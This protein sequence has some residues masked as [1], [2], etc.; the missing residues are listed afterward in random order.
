MEFR[1]DLTQVTFAL[2][3]ALDLVGE[4][5]IQHG[6][7]V[8]YIAAECVGALDWPRRAMG[9][10]FLASVLH[11]CGVSST[12]VHHNLLERFEVEDP[13]AHCERGHALLSEFEPFAAVAD[14]VRRHHTPWEEISPVERSDRAVLSANAIFLADRVDVFLRGRSTEE[15]LLTRNEIVGVVETHAGTHFA[16]LL[17]QAFLEAA[18]R[19]AFWLTLEPRHLE[20]YLSGA[21]QSCCSTEISLDQLAHL[22]DIFSRIVDFKST[23]TQSHSRG[24]ARLSKLLAELAGLPAE[25]CRLLEIA[26]LLHDIGKLRVP[27]RILAK[28]DRLDH[29]EMAAMMRHPF[30][31]YHILS[32]IQGLEEVAE[33]ASFH[34][35]T[36]AGDGYPFRLPAE[37]L[38]LPAR[39]VAVA[40]VVQALAQTRPYRRPLVSEPVLRIIR[41][42]AEAKKLDAGLVDLVA[43]NLDVCMAA[44]IS[45]QPATA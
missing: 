6:K 32:K 36:P 1:V 7:R 4:D 2:S 15:I 40:D 35:E 27:D 45:A 24:V 23:F 26:G 37:R 13:I 41:T 11:D 20:R 30:E 22:A 29:W 42:M 28:P 3:D 25:Q 9:E 5:I 31:S 34:H 8:A 17:T 12:E 10:L 33:W 18:K 16:P 21:A 44:A 19:E 43:E 38:S 14:I 39:I